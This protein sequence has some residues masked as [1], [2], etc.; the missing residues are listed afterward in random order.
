MQPLLN[1]GPRTVSPSSALPA[2]SGASSGE[3]EYVIRSENDNQNEVDNYLLKPD[4]KASS[5]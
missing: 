1:S 4:K 5:F 2:F 3:A